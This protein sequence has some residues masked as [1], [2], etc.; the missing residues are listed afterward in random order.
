MM[1]KRAIYIGR[2]APWTLFLNDE[3]GPTPGPNHGTAGN[4]Q[5]KT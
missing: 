3:E 4:L 1:M 2:H 5:P